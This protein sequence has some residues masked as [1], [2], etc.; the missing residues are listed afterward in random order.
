MLLFF[1]KAFIVLAALLASVCE[2]A[3]SFPPG[4]ANTLPDSGDCRM[5]KDNAEW[6][7]P[8]FCGKISAPWTENEDPK[9][10]MSLV[11][12]LAMIVYNKH[13]PAAQEDRFLIA[14]LYTPKNRDIYWASVPKG[15]YSNSGRT[16][17][18][19]ADQNLKG[20]EFHAEHSAYLLAVGPPD[21]AEPGFGSF[22]GVYGWTRTSIEAITTPC[23]TNA[24]NCKAFLD[25][26]QISYK[27]NTAK[28]E[29]ANRG[30]SASPSKT[31]GPSD[32][33]R[34]PGKKD[35]PD[36]YRERSPDK[37][38]QR[39]RDLSKR[40]LVVKSAIGEAILRRAILRINAEQQ[41]YLDTTSMLGRE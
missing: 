24:H 33:S 10:V 17:P 11:E 29:E 40:A 14:A 1:S 20:G 32:R 19:I 39:T 7:K 16:D 26:K 5:L 31:A 2:A 15:K 27:G 28:F 12:R 8:M 21:N 36:N 9:Q 13:Q 34:S 4:Y 38:R 41:R 35:R 25:G 23:R 3:Y 22:M 37:Q 18:E 30:R 6:Q